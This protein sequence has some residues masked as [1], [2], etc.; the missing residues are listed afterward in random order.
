MVALVRTEFR[1]P[2]TRSVALRANWLPIEPVWSPNA[3]QS[4]TV[5]SLVRELMFVVNLG[6]YLVR[7]NLVVNLLVR[8]NL[9]VVNLLGLFSSSH[10]VRVNLLEVTLFLSSSSGFQ[11]AAESDF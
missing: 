11:A 6:V 7:V 3:D 2:D 9:L 5:A 4:Q 8:V 1:P 10:F